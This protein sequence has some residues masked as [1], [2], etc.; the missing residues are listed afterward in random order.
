MAIRSSTSASASPGSPG[1][2]APARQTGVIA[3]NSASVFNT[4]ESS[5]WA[6]G[7]PN[8]AASAW[9]EFADEPTKG[10]G[11]LRS[12]S[13]AGGTSVS[14]SYDEM[15]RV[16]ASSQT[17]D[18]ITYPFSYTY[19]LA[20]GVETTTLPSGR[21]LKQCYDVAGRAESVT[22]T[23]SG[24]AAHDYISQITYDSGGGM[25]QAQL[26]NG[27]WEDWDY[28]ARK[29]VTSIK[30]G[31]TAG[32]SD[33]LQ[34]AYGYGTTANNGNVLSQAIARPSFSVTQT[35][36]IDPL[37]R[38]SSVTEGTES[39]TFDYSPTGNMWVATASTNFAAGSFTPRTS[40]WYNASNRLVN[41]GLG[42]AYDLA[43]NQTAIGG[44]TNTFDA[45]N[46]LTS[47]TINSVTTSYAYDGEGRR[48]KN[49]SMVMV[50][51]AFGKLAAEYGG[52]VTSA[53]R[54]YLTGDHLGSTRLVTNASGNPTKCADYL[55]F[56]EEIGQGVNGRGTCYGFT[57]PRQ[58]FT[59]KERD[60]ETGLDYFGARYF[61]GAQG[62][63][64][65]P[66]P[67]L[68]M[69]EFQPESDDEDDVEES[70]QN[71]N[72]YIGQPQNWNRY[73]YAFNNPQRFIDPDG[74]VVPLVLYGAAAAGGAYLASPA[75][76]RA[77]IMGSQFLSRYGSRVGP[78]LAQ[79]SQYIT[80]AAFQL[81]PVVRG[82][83]I[84]TLRGAPE[85]FR[86]VRGIDNFANGV[87]TSIKSLNIFAK[88][89][90]NLNRLA[91]TLSGYV[92][93]LANYSGGQIP[94]RILQRGDIARKVLEVVLPKGNL[95]AAQQ[96]VLLR[97]QQQAA[98]DGVD[99]IYYQAR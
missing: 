78:V 27:K 69:I 26:G 32:A 65:G 95:S 42:I 80:N 40:T 44:Y 75:G 58:K 85:A 12:V 73:S 21:S 14:Y 96:Q 51:D 70:R 38:L 92:Q 72:Q 71:F 49:G 94:G 89:Y 10:K 9:T 77:V 87:A 11:R 81:G 83:V 18:G 59:G 33:L 31:A 45:E 46:R 36:G 6:D 37:N 30:L 66:D 7:N 20:G 57:D 99:V 19:N 23:K 55:P 86:N 15:G 47:S 62:R 16:T 39:R 74:R 52:A 61:S 22:G 79:S 29:Q 2:P 93:Q 4:P 35:Y 64:T 63:F 48:V 82:R 5:T 3:P 56:G 91:S 25:N 76:Q 54:E 24:E 84:E 90:Q 88:S 68:P 41:T 17:T 67:F 50:Y 98:R 8:L 28:N 60:G 53:G 43:G 13:V 97:V 1:P 34:L